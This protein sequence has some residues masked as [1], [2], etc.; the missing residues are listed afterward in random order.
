MTSDTPTGSKTTRLPRFWVAPLL[1]GCCFALGYGMTHRLVTL[2]TK[3]DAPSKPEGFASLA[4]PGESLDSLR[5]RNSSSGSL[6]VDM[7]AIEVKEAAERKVQEEAEKEAKRQADLVKE[8]ELALQSPAQPDWTPPAW[9][10]LEPGW[11]EP[12]TPMPAAA[13]ELN[14]PA[15]LTDD[16]VLP[17]EPA[18]APLADPVFDQPA[19]LMPLPPPAPMP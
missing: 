10:Q 2:Q 14:P 7:A 18:A 17:Y 16:P 13:V 9:A 15:L 3:E 12:A 1:A 6:D 8:N 5:D 19:P 11:T 4:F